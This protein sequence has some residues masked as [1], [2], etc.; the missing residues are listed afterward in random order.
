[1]GKQYTMKARKVVGEIVEVWDGEHFD[2]FIVK[3]D[4]SSDWITI[5]ERFVE[6]FEW[7]KNEKISLMRKIK[8]WLLQFKIAV[9]DIKFKILM[10]Y[11]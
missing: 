7:S 8:G 2:Y 11:M 9:L 6:S 10:K 4:G 1:M 3:E 5:G